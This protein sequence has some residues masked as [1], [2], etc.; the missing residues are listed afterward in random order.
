MS[1]KRID[2]RP[3][4]L[5]FVYANGCPA[6]E[7]AE[8]E[9]DAVMRAKPALLGLKLEVNGPPARNMG[10]KIRATPTWIYRVG[11]Q[12]TVREGFAPA[13]A[14]VEWIEAAEAKLA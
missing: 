11:D 14:I 4:T 5:F 1:F 10:V 12:A 9:F 8:P 6:C 2:L 3:R 7:E 13:Q